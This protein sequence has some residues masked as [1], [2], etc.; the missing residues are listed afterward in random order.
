VLDSGNNIIPDM[1]AVHNLKWYHLGIQVVVNYTDR[2]FHNNAAKV[3]N[4]L[5]RRPVEYYFNIYEP[6]RLLD[7][8]NAKPADW[9]GA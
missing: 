7:C 2:V 5:W 4:K 8:P 3:E 1:Y 6:L 9:G